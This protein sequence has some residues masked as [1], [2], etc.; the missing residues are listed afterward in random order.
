MK[1]TQVRRVMNDLVKDISGDDTPRMTFRAFTTRWLERKGLE[2]KP[3]TAAHYGAIVTGFLRH[4]GDLGDLDIADI[5]RKH[6]EA[7]RAAESARVTPRHV[8][9]AVKTLRMIFKS[10]REEG[11]LLDNPVEFVRHVKDSTPFERRP[12]AVDEVATVLKFCDPEWRSMV[13]FGMYTLQRPIDLA[14]LTWEHVDL[15][16]GEIRLTTHKT[17][18]RQKIPICTL[19][20]Q[21]IVNL[22]SSDD[23]T[24]PIHPR[25]AAIVAEDGRTATL[26]RQFSEI[27]MRAGLIPR[28]SHKK[29]KDT[30]GLGRSGKRT[31]NRLSFYSL[32][33]AGV[34]MMKAA[35]IPLASVMEIAG[36]DSEAISSVYT[37]LGHDDLLKAVNALP[38]VLGGAAVKGS[39]K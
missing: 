15:E 25:S 33:H 39:A 29:D 12:F 38:S 3:S 30:T 24:A 11:L 7:Y 2:C 4:L 18:R 21:H 16:A 19:L 6:I 23:P 8:N 32:R 14:T 36:H 35:N 5:D 10:A 17:Q 22:P 27:L 9:H 28:K 31:F 26:S 13:L 34:T 1:A 37:H 20:R